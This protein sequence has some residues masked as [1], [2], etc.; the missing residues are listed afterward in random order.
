MVVKAQRRV[1]GLLRNGEVADR[2]EG[3]CNHVIA[4][5]LIVLALIACPN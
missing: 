4:V 5:L 1:V 2:L 3:G